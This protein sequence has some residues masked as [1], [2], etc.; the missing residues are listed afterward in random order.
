MINVALLGCGTVGGGVCDILKTSPHLAKK[1]Q[2]THILDK[3]INPN[4]DRF[5]NNFDVIINDK[6]VDIIVEALGGIEP[7]H[8]YISASLNAKKHVVTSN[9]A[10]V[11]QYMEEFVDL[12]IQNN[13]GL[14]LEATAGGGI[15]WIHNLM[16]VKR[17]DEIVSFS[18][19]INGTSNF[20]IDKMEKENLDFNTALKLAQEKGYAEKDPSADINGDDVRAKACISASIAFDTLVDAEI[21]T[22]GIRNLTHEDIEVFENLGLRVRMVTRAL[23]KDDQYCICVEPQ[24]SSLQTLEANTPGYFNTVS[25]VGNTIGELKFFG[26]GAGAYPTANAIIQDILDC[27][28]NKFPAYNITN[29]LQ[30]NTEIMPSTYLY[31]TRAETELPRNAIMIRPGYFEVVGKYPD[32]ASLFLEKMTEKD[33]LTFMASMQKVV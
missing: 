10:V 8:T 6:N 5:T 1:F 13:V 12:S 11:A 28:D 2:I 33:P 23:K 26:A 32:E 25:L 4:D 22:S 3:K 24:L 17:I 15:P 20:I 31:R 30:F 18:G 16:R 21:P 7:A 9:K 27:I 19:I 29:P 14:F